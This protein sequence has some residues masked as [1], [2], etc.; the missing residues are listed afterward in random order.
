MHVILVGWCILAL[1]YVW[2]TAHVCSAYVRCI[3]AR[4]TEVS[5]FVKDFEFVLVCCIAC[6]KYKTFSHYTQLKLTYQVTYVFY[7]LCKNV[8]DSE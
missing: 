8:F 5:E 1:V 6:Y 2:V 3:M 7:L 4:D